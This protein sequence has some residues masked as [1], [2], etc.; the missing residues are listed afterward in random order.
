LIFFIKAI[1]FVPG[2]AIFD[3][4]NTFLDSELHVHWSKCNSIC[5]DGAAAMTG[6]NKGLV[7]RIQTVAP[8]VK[9][10]HCVLHRT[11]LASKRISP[12]LHDVLSNA[13]RAVNFIKAKPLNS[14]LFAN[15]CG[16]SESDHIKLLLHT[17]V[18]WLSRG[19]FLERLFEL[20]EEVGK[21]LSDHDSTLGDLFSDSVWLSQLAYL[22]DIFA[23]VNN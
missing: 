5:T 10:N 22:T 13:I 3:L 2:E 11:A 21:F 14:R 23:L 15:L 6:R 16:E 4:L 7:A 1:A 12:V 9:G 8:H 18:R 19:R 17:E 20:R